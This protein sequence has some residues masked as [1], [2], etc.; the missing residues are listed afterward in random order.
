[1]NYAE[2][3]Q[4]DCGQRGNP[5]FKSQKKMKATKPT[6]EMV[7]RSVDEFGKEV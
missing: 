4:Y 3:E 5:K 1:M 7:V 6:L 2:I